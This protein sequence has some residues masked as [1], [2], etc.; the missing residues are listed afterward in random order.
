MARY[1]LEKE[2]LKKM[3]AEKVAEL[4]EERAKL[5]DM[6]TKRISI[7]APLTDAEILRQNARCGKISL[8]V[9]K[10]QD[11]LDHTEEEG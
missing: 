10:L 7:S 11:M 1:S 4:E 5:G 2:Q 8:E 9:S 6:F 3:H